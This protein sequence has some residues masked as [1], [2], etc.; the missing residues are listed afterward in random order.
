MDKY[1]VEIAPPYKASLNPKPLRFSNCDIL[2][3]IEKEA[4]HS[5]D[6]SQIFRTN[7][8]RLEQVWWH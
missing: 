7:W 1:H 8:E 5:V 2:F 3:L 4:E 6:N